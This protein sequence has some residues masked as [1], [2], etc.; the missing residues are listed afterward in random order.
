MLQSWRRH[1]PI[2]IRMKAGSRAMFVRRLRLLNVSFSVH[3]QTPT[4]RMPR[5]SNWKIKANYEYQTGTPFR[6]IQAQSRILWYDKSANSAY[7]GQIRYGCGEN[8]DVDH[9]TVHHRESSSNTKL[10]IRSY[11]PT[12]W[13]K[14]C[15]NVNRKSVKTNYI[16]VHKLPINKHIYNGILNKTEQHY[17]LI[18][19]QANIPQLWFTTNFLNFIQCEYFNLSSR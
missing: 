7:L 9:L 10:S 4:A 12:H 17:P 19:Y 13:H 15:S 14:I 5:P 8:T 6:E 16:K 11:P 3:A 18:H 1:S 2:S